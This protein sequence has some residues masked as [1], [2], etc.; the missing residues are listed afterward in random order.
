MPYTLAD[1][2]FFLS[3]PAL[4]VGSAFFSGSETA[5][6]GLSAHQ[7]YQLAQRGGVVG[8]AVGAL[9]ADQS[10]LLVT[11]MLGN[12]V[13]NILFLVVSS[14]LVLKLEGE[15]VNPLLYA[16]VSLGP[17]FALTALGDVLPKV[18]ASVARMYWVGLTA[19][20]LLAVH[21]IA[22]PLTR[23]LNVA[24]I[25]PLHRL[26]APQL[27]PREL[28][29]G[30]M[31]ELLRM[32][33]SRGIIGSDEQRLIREVMGLSQI[34]V[35][36]IMVP[37]VD[38]LGVDVRGSAQELRGAVRSAKMGAVVAYEGDIDHVVGVIYTRQLMLAL[39]RDPGV[40][41]ADLV[42]NVR[43]VPEIQRVDQL[44]EDFRR[45]G[46]KLAIAVDEYGGTAGLVSLK[47]VVER[48]VGDLDETAVVDESP[49]TTQQITPNAW[50][51]SGRLSIRDWQET[52]DPQELAP[53]VVTIGGLVMAMLGRTPK[54]GDHVQLRNV[55]V[56][57]EKVE[58]G[59]IQTVLLHVLP[60]D[61]SAI[62]LRRWLSEESSTPERP[63]GGG[64]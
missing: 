39:R 45:T 9:L 6:F 47:N 29:V 22:A 5:L 46:T 13:I 32:S 35:R 41:L 57:V 7:R 8:K 1:L 10:L 14:M 20:P 54:P 18:T 43:F 30:E 27:G 63:G 55:Q 59:R 16:A 42:R 37:R 60:R 11:L 36:D 49:E 17:V 25:R 23:L 61:E 4:L 15:R 2:P 33:Q 21:R 24:L 48:I 31:E 44:L 56:V 19:I 58:R 38:I 34:K 40:K 28:S 64:G 50:R 26:F 3:L 12:M 53:R 52:F 62:D 51:V